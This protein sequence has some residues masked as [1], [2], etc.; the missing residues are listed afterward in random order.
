MSELITRNWMQLIPAYGRDYNTGVEAETAFRS[1]VDWCGDYSLGF[2]LCS[3][4]NFAKGTKVILY[5][6]GFR[7]QKVVTV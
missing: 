6:N 2:M 3:I 7:K 1:G 4:Q 5:Y